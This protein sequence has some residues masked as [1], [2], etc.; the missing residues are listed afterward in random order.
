MLLVSLTFGPGKERV[1]GLW[2]TLTGPVQQQMNA[3][4]HNAVSSV[5]ARLA[6]WD[7]S[8]E[9]WL[10]SPLFGVGTG[11]FPTAAS[12]WI[13]SHHPTGAFLKSA[14]A[15]PHNQYLLSMVRW[16]VVGLLLSLAL[17]YIW[18][19]TGFR[20]QWHDSKAIPLIALSGV[21]LLAHGFFSASLEEHF[22]TIF[23]LVVFSTGLSECTQNQ[24]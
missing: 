11:G 5:T 9:L 24:A 13:A 10:D 4:Q 14:P 15:H 3:E 20:Y 19:R 18:I 8:Y 7:M 12:N 17:F 1:Q 6:W 22:S 16:G 21:G 2:Q 23:A